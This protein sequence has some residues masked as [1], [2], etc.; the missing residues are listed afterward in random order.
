METRAGYDAGGPGGGDQPAL[1]TAG[2]LDA[3]QARMEAMA[4]GAI[5]H[6][7]QIT[8]GRRIGGSVYAGLTDATRNEGEGVIVE[9][10]RLLV[11][12]D[13]A[14]GYRRHGISTEEQL[15]AHPWEV[16]AQAHRV[17]LWR[18]VDVEA[19]ESGGE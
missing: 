5:D 7:R 4:S 14:E 6:E 11:A 12:C 17:S 19:G 13:M 1:L 2:E 9:Y 10:L 15:L 3:L 8:L 16:R 18:Q